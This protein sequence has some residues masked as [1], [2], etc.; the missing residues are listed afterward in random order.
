MTMLRTTLLCALALG[1][2]SGCADNALNADRSPTDPLDE[3]DGDVDT[4]VDTD[5][6]EQENDFLAMAPAQ[7]DVYVFIANPA[8][9]TVTRIQVF[10]M[11]VVTAEV[12]V[13]PRVV[14]VTP[15]YAH[16][17]VF[18]RG[19]DTVSVIESK[20]LAM[21][22]VPVRDNYNQMLMSHDGAWVGLFHD[23]SAERPDDPPPDG[24]QSFNEVSFVSVPGGRV[25]D[26]A[27]SYNPRDIQFSAD[28]TLAVVVS[29]DALA[30]IDLTQEYL[31]PVMIE[32]SDE[33]DPPSAE[34]VVLSPNGD[35]AFV[36][37]FG[38]EDLLLINLSDGSRTS[39]PIGSN[40]TDLDLSPDG[41]QAVVVARAAGQ[42]WV[43]EADQPE[44]PARVLELPEALLAGSVLFDRTG[45]RAVLYTTATNTRNFAIWDT[46]TDRVDVHDL[47]KPV[48]AMAFT[49]TGDSLLVLHPQA[50]APDTPP[51]F[52]G[53]WVM[54]LV[55]LKGTVL[56]QNPIKLP[57]EP[58]GFANAGDGLNGYFIMDGV[59]SLVEIDYRSLLYN[60][61]G[62][63]SPPVYVGVLP[64]LDDE[65]GVRPPA[66]ASQEHPLGRISFFHPDDN[67]LETITGF[68]L[69]GRIEE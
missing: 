31:E 23:R 64:D 20:T 58:I 21:K 54:S 11:D 8:R 34:E 49:P 25:F 69:N 57:A 60:D 65:D 39:L 45:D 43:Y 41:T 47:V 28:G 46:T 15:D 53:S 12:G 33:L 19:D 63:K 30:L 22:T 10:S 48:S 13:D 36:R 3:G 1:A 68:E 17:A 26:M 37:Q 56:R 59:P 35:Y 61:I 29:D 32:V 9:S 55:S 18:N 66:W 6:P 16:A 62:L 38:A 44:L 14:R 7:T 40:P 50:D 4:D 2:L 24:L 42:V 67:A 52:Q 51:D 27:V 5:P